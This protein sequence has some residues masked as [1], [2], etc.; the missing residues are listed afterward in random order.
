MIDVQDLSKH[1]Q[2]RKRHEGRLAAL[3]DFTTRET[4]TVRAVDEVSFGV[5]QGRNRRLLRPEWSG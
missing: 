3:R 2:L 1:F 5:A 4:R